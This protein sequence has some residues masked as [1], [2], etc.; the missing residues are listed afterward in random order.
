MMKLFFFSHGTKHSKGVCNLIHPS[1][2]DK[3]EYSFS[4][5]YGR[6]VLITIVVN[7]IHLSLFNIYAPNNL[8]EQLEF[9]QDLNNCL[10]DKS[11]LTTLIVGGDWNCTLSKNDKIGSKP[12]KATNY[13]NLLLTTMDIL[14]LVDIQSVRH[15]KQRKYS[16]E[17]K[18][19]K[20]K[21]RI[22]FSL[23]AKN[24]TQFIK[25]SEIYPS[26]APDHKAIFIS[27]SWHNLTPRGPGLWKF[28]NSLLNDEHYVTKICETYDQACLY[29]SDLVD[30]RLFWE[31]LEMEIRTATISFSRKLAKT[32]NSRAMEIQRQIDVLDDVICNN[33]H[34]PDIDQVLKEFDELK[35]ELQTIYSKKG[36][37]AMF[38]SKCRWVEKSECP[39]K[40]FFNLEKRNYNKKTI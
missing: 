9:L 18:A 3:V 30:K 38:R 16:Y 1:V 23:V 24:L 35:I 31:M 26:I 6:I 21:S 14:D 10:I 37:A 20:V 27:L 25:K 34:S 36:E 22:D 17:S 28:N 5:K 19:L 13:R 12:W 11:E 4:D 15:P 39:T 7:S 8:N 32:T 2:Q 29:Y 40:Y 33:F